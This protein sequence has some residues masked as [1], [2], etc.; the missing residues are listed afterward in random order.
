[1]SVFEMDFKAFL[2]SL[3]ALALCYFLWKWKKHFVDPHLYFSDIKTFEGHSVSAKWANLPKTLAYLSLLSFILA[4]PDPR[5]L[6]DHHRENPNDES[7]KS[8]A[9]GIA[10]YLVLDQ[11]GSMAEELSSITRQTKVDLLKQVTRQFIAGDPNTGLQ[12]L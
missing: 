1:M 11:S 7:V 5:L 10:I 2:A 4:F 8:P 12:R 3:G 6:I 9:E